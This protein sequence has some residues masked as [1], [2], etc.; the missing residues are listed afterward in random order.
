MPGHAPLPQ[1]LLG[2]FQPG[3]Q[4]RS[5]AAWDASYLIARQDEQQPITVEDLPAMDEFSVV[6]LH[7]GFAII[8]D[9]GALVFDDWR[10]ERL[11][12]D[13]LETEFDR[14]FQI[15]DTVRCVE[16]ALDTLFAERAAGQ[17]SRPTAAVLGDLAT[18]RGRLVEAGHEYQPGSHWADV[19]AFRAA[20][21]DRWCVDDALK[22]LLLV[23][24]AAAGKAPD[25]FFYNGMKSPERADYTA[26]KHGG[27]FE[28]GASERAAYLAEELT[29]LLTLFGDAT[30]APPALVV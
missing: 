22:N 5:S 13:K 19:R 24:E 26:W 11:R 8:H 28:G 3:Q 20:L 21:E 18:L 12:L 14:T 25:L 10:P 16:R 23:Y 29:N 15:L 17:K 7:G 1:A 6:P 2:F 4:S 30:P 27:T 9:Q